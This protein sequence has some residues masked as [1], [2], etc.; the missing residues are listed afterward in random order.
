MESFPTEGDNLLKEQRDQRVVIKLN[1]HIGNHSLV[2]QFE[3]DLAE[4]QNSPEVNK[5]HIV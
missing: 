4:E 1:I 3:W 5:C 2:D